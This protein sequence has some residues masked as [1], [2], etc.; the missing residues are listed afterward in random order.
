MGRGIASGLQRDDTVAGHGCS[1]TGE[2]VIKICRDWLV[3]AQ[4]QIRPGTIQVNW[5][6][7]SNR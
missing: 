2:S 1:E 4:T 3:A 5:N 7:F 6:R